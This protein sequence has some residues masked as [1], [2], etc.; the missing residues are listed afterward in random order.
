LFFYLE[1]NSEAELPI[2]HPQAE[3]LE[4]DKKE[5]RI[6]RKLQMVFGEKIE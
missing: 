6:Q 1:N 3:T 2:P 4:C 5:R